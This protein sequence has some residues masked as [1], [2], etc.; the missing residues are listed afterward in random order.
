MSASCGLEPDRIVAYKPLID[1]AI[2]QASHKPETVVVY[3]REQ[4]TAELQEE[5]DYDWHDFQA[6]NPAGCVPLDE[7]IQLTYHTSGTTGAH[8]GV[9]RQR[10]D[11]W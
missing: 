2:E 11:I 3:Q 7:I 5:R 6:I 8:K 4:M 10:Q 1:K 9:V